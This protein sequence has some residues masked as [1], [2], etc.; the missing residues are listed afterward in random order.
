MKYKFIIPFAVITLLI[1]TWT[2]AQPGTTSHPAPSGELIDIGGWKLHLY[3]DG[4]D[5]SKAPAVI[6]ENGLRGFSFD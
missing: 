1:N 4:A 2:T 6:F 5:N 3:G